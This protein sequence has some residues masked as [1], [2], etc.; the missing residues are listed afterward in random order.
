MIYICEL[1]LITNHY[2]NSE[3]EC[4]Y[5]KIAFGKILYIYWVK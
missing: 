3:A 5:C 1:Q 2:L 4:K